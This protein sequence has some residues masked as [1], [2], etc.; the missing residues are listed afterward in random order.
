MAATKG[1]S[2]S[3]A[4]FGELLKFKDSDVAVGD[5]DLFRKPSILKPVKVIVSKGFGTPEFDDGAVKETTVT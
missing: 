2:P 4:T 5:R 3:K 1:S